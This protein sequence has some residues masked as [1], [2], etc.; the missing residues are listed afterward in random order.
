MI[1]KFAI[2]GC[3]LLLLSASPATTQSDDGG[4]APPTEGCRLNLDTEKPQFAIG[5]PID[6]R[7]SLHN[8]SR[9]K[10]RTG[11]L[12]YLGCRIEVLLPNGKPAPLTL[13]GEKLIHPMWVSAGSNTIE[14]YRGEVW[15]EEL[16]DLNRAF[17]MTLSGKYMITVH[18]M[19]TSSSD[20][21]KLV[22]VPSNKIK[23]ELHDPEQ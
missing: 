22:D 20:P 10:V 4:C 8:V 6:L 23:V 17:D 1:P 3:I 7:V 18:R 14:L 12:A 21:E 2:C 11:S 9:D 19:V 16:R 5:E 13:W 15:D